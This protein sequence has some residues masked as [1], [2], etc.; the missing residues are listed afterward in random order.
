MA[1]TPEGK[2]RMPQFVRE[3][4]DLELTPEPT[5]PSPPPIH[6]ESKDPVE[7]ILAALN[8][9]K[10]DTKVTVDGHEIKLS[11]LDKVMWPAE[12]G[13]PAFTKRDLIAYYAR[14][15]PF[16]LPHL[17]DRP[18]SI[19]RHP[20]G[21]HGPGFF[22]KH[23]DEAPHFVDQVSIWSSHNDSARDWA[24]CNNLASLIWFGQMLAV[25]IHPWYSR[26]APA[27]GLGTTFE[28]DEG[29]DESVLSFPDYVVFDLDP[30]FPKLP[31]SEW[32]DKS[33]KV[34]KA[35]REVL[36]GLGLRSYPKTSGKTGLH[37]YV[38]LK[39]GHDYAELRTLAQGIG[40]HMMVDKSLEITMEWKVS[41]RPDGV[42]F[43]HNQN[44]RGKTLAAAYSPRPV[45][46][47]PVSMPVRW[48]ELDSVRPPD[49]TMQ[50]VPGLLADRGDAWAD[51]LG[52][53]QSLWFKSG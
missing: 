36:K 31:H 17:K 48:E 6:M 50:N 27:Q 45:P 49:F 46:G 34:G 1:W 37:I 47:A 19:V 42:F 16:F 20:S 32:W 10:A 53:E 26:I 14:V 33:V 41:K 3:R 24:M 35:L 25:E 9:D 22:Q 40:Q 39:R 44:V 52:D 29:L 5:P 12:D 23:V 15:S 43:D 11:S 28:T 51:L 4:P 30:S 13:F 21:I 8:E 2:L 18:L 38:P 7:E